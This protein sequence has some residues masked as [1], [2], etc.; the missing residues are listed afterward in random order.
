MTRDRRPPAAVARS[1]SVK[2]IIGTFDVK[3]RAHQGGNVGTGIGG[4]DGDRSDANLPYGREG[5][6]NGSVEPK[7][8]RCETVINGPVV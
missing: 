2:L 3:Q 1:E 5:D 4:R 8:F 6:G 7:N